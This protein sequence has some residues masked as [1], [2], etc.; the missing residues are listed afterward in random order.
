MRFLMITFIVG[1]LFIGY[2]NDLDNTSVVEKARAD[3]AA[4]LN[5]TPEQI[6]IVYVE[7]VKWPDSC[8]GIYRPGQVCMSVITPGSRIVLRVA[9]NY[10][11]YNASET[12]AIYAG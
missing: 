8:I 5:V 9:G 10:Y 11:F 4:R 2:M 12:Q 6:E 3:L 1:V 7:P